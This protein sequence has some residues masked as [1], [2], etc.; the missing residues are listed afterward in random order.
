MTSARHHQRRDCTQEGQS[1]HHRI[2]LLQR[3]LKRGGR[4]HQLPNHDAL[5]FAAAD[6]SRR[7]DSQSHTISGELGY[8]G[9][10]FAKNI[11][12]ASRIA[13]D[14]RVVAR[15]AICHAGNPP[16]EL[17]A[18]T[19][20]LGKDYTEGCVEVPCAFFRA[21]NRVNQ[22]CLRSVHTA[23]QG[24]C[25]CVQLPNHLR[26]SPAK[27]GAEHCI[28][29]QETARKVS[30]C[31]LA[32]PICAG[33]EKRPNIWRMR[34]TSQSAL[35]NISSLAMNPKR[36]CARSSA[37]RSTEIRRRGFEAL[38]RLGEA[39]L[40]VTV[41]SRAAEAWTKSI[42]LSSGV[43]LGIHHPGS[44]TWGGHIVTPAPSGRARNRAKCPAGSRSIS[45]GGVEGHAPVPTDSNARTKWQANAK[46][47]IAALVSSISR[48]KQ[49]AALRRA[50]GIKPGP[51][52]I[53]SVGCVQISKDWS[54][55]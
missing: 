3:V 30:A 50:A 36:P 28:T 46:S 32:L 45:R 26:S 19:R 53:Q 1:F 18:V 13:C 35:Q 10:S 20:A 7:K 29:V 6:I 17:S 22:L 44:M 21:F 54:A 11:R 51:R 8:T 24:S 12:H 14:R 48:A 49:G 47:P 33:R 16:Y 5:D 15:D 39:G 4:P 55:P 9:Q 34:R 40:P 42:E 23:Y 37:K 52:E 27:A 2:D 41:I 38:I 43:G 25:S 31:S